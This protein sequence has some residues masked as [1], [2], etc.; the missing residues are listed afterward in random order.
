LYLE[1]LVG[2]SV[3]IPL[4]RTGGDQRPIVGWGWL[5]APALCPCS[6][7]L[8]VV[9][10]VS[11]PVAFRTRIATARREKRLRQ[12]LCRRGR[13]IEPDELESKL[14]QGCG[15]FRP[16]GP[17]RWW[18]TEQGSTMVVILRLVRLSFARLVSALSFA[19][20]QEGTREYA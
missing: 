18:W 11:V 8:G 9:A 15:T 10:A 1:M 16:K 17:E 13:A 6:S 19:P 7:R 2:V 4:L 3:R 5:F 14:R 12:A 20:R